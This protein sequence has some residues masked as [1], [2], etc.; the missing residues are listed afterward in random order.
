MGLPILNMDGYLLK[1][2]KE[3]TARANAADAALQSQIT[4]LN[5]G[6]IVAATANAG[7]GWRMID[8]DELTYWDGQYTRVPVNSYS[9]VDKIGGTTEYK[10]GK[11]TAYG[12]PF[13]WSATGFNEGKPYLAVVG[14]QFSA[15][16]TAG[17]IF[18]TGVQIEQKGDDSFLPTYYHEQRYITNDRLSLC[19]VIGFSPA[20][21]VDKAGTVNP[22]GF[23]IF[24]E[25]LV[26]GEATDVEV[27]CYDPYKLLDMTTDAVGLNLYVNFPKTEQEKER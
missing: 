9:G 12:N 26:N 25:Q 4:A 16:V 22:Y 23:R 27:R 19:D 1:K 2:I 6:A 10:S 15:K 24:I 18:K 13:P 17:S 11:I 21:Y 7:N 8:A 14:Y 5:Q 3:E 20:I